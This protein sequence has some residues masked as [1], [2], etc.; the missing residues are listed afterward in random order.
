[1]TRPS[2]GRSRILLVGLDGSIRS[3]PLGCATLDPIRRLNNGLQEGCS[4][5]LQRSCPTTF[6]SDGRPV[7]MKG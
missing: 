4:P 7:E 2:D 3:Y 6:G 1:M 5:T